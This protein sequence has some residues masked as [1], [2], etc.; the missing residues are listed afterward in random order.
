MRTCTHAMCFRLFCYSPDFSALLFMWR[1]LKMINPFAVYVIMSALA[2]PIFPFA[3]A[4]QPFQ[5]VS[6]SV[7]FLTVTHEDTCKTVCLSV[8]YFPHGFGL[9]THQGKKIVS[10]LETIRTSANIFG[11]KFIKKSTIKNVVL[12]MNLALS[13]IINITHFPIVTS[14]NRLS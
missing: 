7:I 11:K 6:S 12:C 2:L 1:I 8:L 14:T 13:Y 4:D 10:R 5:V 3:R 9:I